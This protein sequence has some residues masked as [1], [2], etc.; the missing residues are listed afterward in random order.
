MCPLT[1]QAMQ[2]P[3]HE[4]LQQTPS[5]QAPEPHSSPFEQPAPWLFLIAQLEPLQYA[6][7]AHWPPDEQLVP[8]LLPLQV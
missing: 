2:V 4:S 1:L 5:T 8:Q 7:D 6:F 3:E